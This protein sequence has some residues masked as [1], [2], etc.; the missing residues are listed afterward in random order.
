MGLKD[1]PKPP[2]FRAFIANVVDQD[3]NPLSDMAIHMV[4]TNPHY[5]GPQLTG[6]TNQFGYMAWQDIP[7]QLSPTHTRV[8]N[9]GRDI[10]I[11][12][13]PHHF[14]GDNVTIQIPIEPELDK[15][16]GLVLGDNHVIE[17]AGG[18]HNFL[19]ASLFWA[20]WGYQ[21]DKDRLGQN[22]EFLKKHEVDYIR[23]LGIV[24]PSHGWEDRTVDYRPYYLD[25]ITNLTDYVYDNFGMR[26]QWT[27]FGG[28]DT[29]PTYPEQEEIVD[30]FIALA[31]SRPHKIFSIEVANEYYATDF[32]LSN[33][34]TLGRKLAEQT[35]NLVTLSAPASEE[36]LEVN[37]VYYDSGVDAAVFHLDRSTNGEGGL[38]RPV[39][40]P[41]EVQFYDNTPPVWINNEPIGPESSVNS[42]DDPLRLSM[43]AATTYL[44]G[45]GAFVLHTGAG[46]RGGGAADLNRGRSSNIWE[47]NNVESI[48]NAIKIVRDNLP[49]DIANWRRINTSEHDVYVTTHPFNTSY[50]RE[51][52][53]QGKL[54]RAFAARN[55]KD[56]FVVSVL[57]CET[58][59]RFVAR[60]NMQFKIIDP[61]HDNLGTTTLRLGETLSGVPYG[62]ILKGKIF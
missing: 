40:Q 23:V 30:D 18:P 14:D 31:R 5:H 46:I 21:N 59:V 19:G 2:V 48:L 38:W 9:P 53:E 7:I 3:G 60:Y 43:F 55:D 16:V 29:C 26:I 49:K 8:F 15:P 32:P 58:D 52:Q 36:Q 10:D 6:V 11:T 27:I 62:C 28:I 37:A 51:A 44:C 57:K 34:R 35:D 33:L 24:G 20:L 13:S 50:L 54:L 25:D 39:R 4:S 45:M 61:I 17:D 22:L 1:K 42:D 56:E 41:W 47:V 12:I